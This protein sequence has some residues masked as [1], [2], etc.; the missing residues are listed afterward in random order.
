VIECANAV[1]AL[2]PY[3]KS[4]IDGAKRLGGR[5]Y[6]PLKAWV[7]AAEKANAVRE[8]VEATYGKS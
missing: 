1:V 5:W 4:F 7:F 3:D 6:P 2:T 8:L